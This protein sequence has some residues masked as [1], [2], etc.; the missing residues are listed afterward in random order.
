[1]PF[2]EVEL[3][4]ASRALLKDEESGFFVNEESWFF[5]LGKGSRNYGWTEDPT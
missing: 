5:L 1:M 4:R 3:K 2:K